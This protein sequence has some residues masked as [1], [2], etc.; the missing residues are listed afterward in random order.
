MADTVSC[1]LFT[2]ANTV[3]VMFYAVESAT[4][5]HIP[6]CILLARNVLCCTPLTY[7]LSALYRLQSLVEGG[8]ALVRPWWL[9]ES[10]HALNSA[11]AWLD[12]LLVEQRTFSH[13]SRGLA[14]G[15]AMTYVLWI[16][17]IKQLSGRVGG[18]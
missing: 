11:A 7:T 2:L 15:L 4:Q 1:A 13:G 16:L 10:V 18:S 3:T 8:E 6:S 14:V 9:A 12:L 5:V 17:A